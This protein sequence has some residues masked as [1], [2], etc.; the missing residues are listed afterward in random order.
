[1]EAALGL[2]VGDGEGVLDR[3]PL[4]LSTEVTA[5]WLV[6]IWRLHVRVLMKKETHCYIYMNKRV[7]EYKIR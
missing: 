4:L 5:L 3:F 7:S 2:Q 6:Y 1:M